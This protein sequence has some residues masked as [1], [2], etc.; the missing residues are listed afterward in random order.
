MKNPFDA[1]RAKNGHVGNGELESGEESPSPTGGSFPESLLDITAEDSGGNQPAVSY[2]PLGSAL[3]VSDE[4]GRPYVVLPSKDIEMGDTARTALKVLGDARL[5]YSRG[6]VVVSLDERENGALEARPVS[7]AC[8]V[9]LL[10]EAAGVRVWKQEKERWSLVP[11]LSVPDAVARAIVSSISAKRNLPELN[12]VAS[13]PLLSQRDGKLETLPPGYDAGSGLFVASKSVLPVV[14]LE[15]AVSDL[16]ELFADF[17][18]VDPGDRSRAVAEVIAPAMK[19]AGLIQGN[20][21]IAVAEAD[22]SQA[23][24]TYRCRVLAALYG[25]EP[26]LVARRGPGGVGSFDESLDT[27]L[28]SGRMCIIIDNVRGVLSSQSLES[29]RSAFGR[30]H[31]VRI[32]HLGSVDIR[33]E[34]AVIML[35]S[36]GAELTVDLANRSAVVRTRKLDLARRRY[37]YIDG[38]DLLQHVI[39]NQ[40]YYM[41]C[42]HAVIRH[43]HLAGCPVNRDCAHPFADWAAKM[44]WIVQ[45][46]MGCAPLLQ[47]HGPAIRRA[48]STGLSFMRKIAVAI[49]NT[50]RLDRRL[51]SEELA[52][53]CAEE[54]ISVPGMRFDALSDQ[55]TVA[56]VIGMKFRPIFR[57]SNPVTV[58]GYTVTRYSCRSTALE[59]A[60]YDPAD[61]PL[62]LN[63]RAR[64]LYEFNR[65]PSVN[66]TPGAGGDPF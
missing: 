16:L 45:N 29:I 61:D 49:E 27:A 54:D 5:A 46:V 26:R 12:G 65:I 52:I 6:G 60:E 2:A 57:E 8:M 1:Y 34:N 44:D 32:P 11:V 3:P 25:E 41:G 19:H 47:A 4:R 62:C 58:D 18:F 17:D 39:H 30:T 21:P 13:Y 64:Y 20:L 22:R 53:L 50:H 42:I 59:S 28:L 23:G 48:S 15:K 66:H 10:Q 31:T 56:R 24:K 63:P 7:A 33:T 36:N 55:M 14:P 9:T 37:R 35:T 51:S 43:W 38:R 40:P